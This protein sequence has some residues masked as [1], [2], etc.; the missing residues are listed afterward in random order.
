VL[1]DKTTVVGLT[2]VGLAAAVLTF[3]T[4]FSLAVACGFDPR[5]AWL[6]PVS[7]DVAGLV[8]LRIWLREGPE[9]AQALMMACIVLSVAGNATQHG[10]AAYNMPIPWWVIVVV[11]AVPPSVLAAVVHLAHRVA[12]SGAAS[13]DAAQERDTGPVQATVKG[14]VSPDHREPDRHDEVPAIE[15]GPVDQAEPSRP[16]E[17][18]E[19]LP[20]LVQWSEKDGVP[21]R[22]A[23]MKRFG[24]GTT[25]ATRLLEQLARTPV[26]A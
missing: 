8:A 9:F 1:K 3:T 7:V 15:S 6:L 24:V 14:V 11:S 16:A 26:E 13:S 20:D 4:L 22:N 2:V 21:S 12:R 17:D 10:L 19:L 18:D 23:V 25:R 5:L